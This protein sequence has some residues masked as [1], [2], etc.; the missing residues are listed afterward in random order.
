MNQ[1]LLC[2]SLIVLKVEGNFKVKN[3]LARDFWQRSKK[4]YVGA[5]QKKLFKKPEGR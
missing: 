4:P 5:L 3:V 2:K 1:D